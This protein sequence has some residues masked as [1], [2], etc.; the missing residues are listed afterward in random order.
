VI[1]VRG[2]ST[3]AAGVAWANW[4]VG[5]AKFKGQLI[6]YGAFV[7]ACFLDP[8]GE[9]LVFICER[10]LVSLFVDRTNLTFRFFVSTEM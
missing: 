8:G 3:A 10:L 1:L 4:E 5:L 2:E 6:A 9:C 7:D